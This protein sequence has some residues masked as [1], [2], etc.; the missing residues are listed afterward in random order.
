MSHILADAQNENVRKK[1]KVA[2]ISAI[3]AALLVSGGTVFASNL[4][5]GHYS[6]NVTVKEV[7]A[8]TAASDSL[9]DSCT[10][11]ATTASCAPASLSPGQSFVVTLQVEN[12]GS[13]N[14]IV[15]LSPSSSNSTVAT[16]SSSSVAGTSVTLTPGS[17]GNLYFTVYAADVPGSATISATI[18]A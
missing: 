18:T 5:T 17:A 4:F 15:N 1:T 8:I 10:F 14:V 9:G 6:Q 2:L 13:T 7:V 16:V 12:S 11:T 3:L